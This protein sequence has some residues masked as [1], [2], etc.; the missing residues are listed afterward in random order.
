[1][2]TLIW[3]RASSTETGASYV[4]MGAQ[5]CDPQ[6]NVGTRGGELRSEARKKISME[7]GMDWGR[8]EQAIQDLRRIKIGTKLS[9]GVPLTPGGDFS[10]ATMC[11][12]Q[13]LEWKS[14]EVS[15]CEVG[16][17]GHTYPAQPS[18]LFSLYSTMQF[19]PRLTRRGPR[20]ANTSLSTTG[21]D[22][23]GRLPREIWERVSNLLDDD[24]LLTTAAVCT[25]FNELCSIV[26]FPM[27]RLRGVG[28]DICS[29][30]VDPTS[31][32]FL[33]RSVR[34]PPIS[35]LSCTFGPT[36]NNIILGLGI[37]L[38]IVRRSKE[39][40]E[41]DLE[42][43][44]EAFGPKGDDD[45]D[46]KM[47]NLHNAFYDVLCAMSTKAGGRV[48]CYDSFAFSVCAATALSW[49]YLEP[50][51]LPVN[52]QSM[53]K[54]GVSRK[55]LQPR[56]HSRLQSKSREESGRIAR[57][58]MAPDIH[59]FM[60]SIFSISSVKL[61][62]HPSASKSERYTVI[63]AQRNHPPPLCLDGSTKIPDQQ[64]DTFLKHLTIRD[65]DELELCRSVPYATLDQFLHR[66]Q[67]LKSIM[68]DRCLDY[69]QLTAALAAVTSVT[70][71]NSAALGPLMDYAD[72]SPLTTAGFPFP[73][74]DP[75]TERTL[76]KKIS[77]RASITAL[78]IG[79]LPLNFKP[80][81]SDTDLEIARSLENIVHLRIWHCW[82]KYQM[83]A[84]LPWI[85]ALPSLSTVVTSEFAGGESQAVL[86]QEALPGVSITVRTV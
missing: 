64:L 54:L 7:K 17:R 47:W 57:V 6:N 60:S 51:Y 21:A 38:N 33:Q 39:L 63:F 13:K 58:R 35:R 9:Q 37:L 11:F 71:S 56:Y 31:L 34:I 75:E 65:L 43:P 70:S 73:G 42:F 66:H 48:L 3:K 85:R 40:T 22:P 27:N 81:F 29:F 61:R 50:R 16:K 83:A 30:T 20:R 80:Q 78:E 28:T 46:K 44:A 86:L 25:T 74:G 32:P 4:V 49:Q 2:Q 23:D 10:V 53:S 14:M 12:F 62:S 59:R 55:Q 41:L 72:S 45:D 79:H 36:D 52:S 76:L 15:T 18:V 82:F 8:T 68:V 5:I 84:M 24:T 67:A 77:N 69:S 19:L 26:K 1:M